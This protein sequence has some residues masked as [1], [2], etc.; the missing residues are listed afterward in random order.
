MAV[1][2]V[3]ALKTGRYI[4][5]TTFRRSG[6]AVSTPVWFVQ[7]GGHVLVWTGA[8]SGKAKRIR[9]SNRVT[10]APCTARGRVTGPTWPATATILPA[11]SERRVENLL[12]HKY[13]LMMPAI[14]SLQALTRLIRRRP[15]GTAIVLRIDFEAAGD[16]G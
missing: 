1:D 16:A 12:A 15:R 3:A 13:R 6:V 7:E 10:V 4:S 2:P 5:L 14:R 8:T 11:G 9:N